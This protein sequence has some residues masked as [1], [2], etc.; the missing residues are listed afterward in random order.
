MTGCWTAAVNGSILSPSAPG[1]AF[2]AVSSITDI[3]ER[4]GRMGLMIITTYVITYRNQF[5]Q[6]VA[7]Q[8]NTSIRY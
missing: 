1:T 3:N 4:A 7:T 8:T 6:V 2:P 5:D